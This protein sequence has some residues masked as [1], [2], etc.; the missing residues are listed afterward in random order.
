[1]DKEEQLA[2]AREK[3][4]EVNK[5]KRARLFEFKSLDPIV[6]DALN[7]CAFDGDLE[8]VIS[9]EPSTPLEQ[10]LW[11]TLE[12]IWDNRMFLN[13]YNPNKVAPP[14][15]ELLETSIWED[16]YTRY[17]SVRLEDSDTVCTCTDDELMEA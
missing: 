3:A 6:G 9:R 13:D 2:L 14:E 15:M 16:G 5:G 4:A 8:T 11:N 12:L 10:E 7:R 17:Y 1:M